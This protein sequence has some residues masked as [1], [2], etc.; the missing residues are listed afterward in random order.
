MPTVFVSLPAVGATAT[1]EMHE[2]T[3][4]ANA[5]G[6]RCRLTRGTDALTVSV[7]ADDPDMLNLLATAPVAGHSDGFLYDEDCVHVATS[8]AGAAEPD[9]FTL[10]NPHGAR[11]G[12]D[13][14]KSWPIATHRHE[15]GWRIDLTIP[16][17]AGAAA[18]G[19]AVLRFFRGVNHEV[20][21]ITRAF[22]HPMDVA[23]FAVVVLEPG[24]NAEAV[25]DRFLDS[26][27][28]AKRVALHKAITQT[29][30]RIADALTKPGRPT[31]S[32]ATAHRLAEARV[33]RPILDSVSFLC[34]NEQHFQEG[35]LD[36]W[37]IEGDRRW[38]EIAI[39]RN[40]QVWSLRGHHQNRHDTMWGEVMPTWYDKADGR[41]TTPITLGTGVILLSITRLMRIVHGTPALADLR[42]KIGPWTDRCKEA[43]GVH[44]REWLDL[45]GGSGNYLEPYQKGPARIYPRGGSRVC[46]LNRSFA[47]AIPMLH[48]ARIT[49]DAAYPDRVRRMARYFRD[50]C[51][52]LDNGSLVWEYLTG[53]YAADG[54]DISHASCEVAFALLCAAEGIVFTE[55]DVKGIARTLALN[56]F[57]HDDVP[58]ENIRGAHPGF[59]W[60][61]G[62]WASLCGYVPEVLPKITALVEAAMSEAK[63]DF[64]NEG[65]GL[66]NVTTL[67]KA[68]R[69]RAQNA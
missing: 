67:L 63:F 18:V 6:T 54:E 56:V 13:A 44:D 21:G 41:D 66:R 39:E 14:A 48:L 20:H 30:T 53:R 34:W 16:L 45:P 24:T 33:K 27:R 17:P 26:A 32:L 64:A 50:S 40:E 68:R 5:V 25:A 23:D 59:R 19:L 46:P 69:E 31:V 52:T 29:R 2:I 1:L 57:R 51:E 10:A 3:G 62:P 65:W 28:A 60:Y 38:L 8:L 36:L 35:L 15:N 7:E 37:E 61:L 47:L 12:N 4:E 11:R 43:I 42:K 49:G 22:P 58:C 55:N 9:G